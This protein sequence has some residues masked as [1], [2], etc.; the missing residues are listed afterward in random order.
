MAVDTQ[1]GFG[2][3]IRRRRVAAGLTQEELAE[4]TGLSVRAIRDIERGITPK[5]HRSSVDLLMAALGL[6]QE[7]QS[8][9][10]PFSSL[11][12][13]QLP[14]AV[15][16]FVGRS[17]ELA[18]L[19][20]LLGQ[21]DGAPGTTLIS[22]ICGAPGVG[23]TTLAVHWAHSV[24]SQ[25]PDG[26]LYLNLRG[27]DSSGSVMS[28]PEAIGRILDAMQIPAEQRPESPDAR[29]DLYR[30]LLA[31]KRM[32]VVLDNARD[33]DQVRLLLPGSP[34][35]AV[36]IT[37]RSQLVGMVATQDAHPMKLEPLDNTEARELLARR[38]GP[39]R[40]RTESAAVDRLI[41]LSAGLPLALAIVAA[42]AALGPPGLLMSLLEQLQDGQGSLAA[43][44]A[45]DL[46]LD[47]QTVFSWSYQSLSAPAARMFRLLGLHPGPDINMPAAASLAGLSQ[48]E[49]RRVL[50]ELARTNLV[51]EHPG[52]RY[53]FHDL[54]RAYSRQLAAETDTEDERRQ[55][56]HRVLDYY[57]GS[58]HAAAELVHPAHRHAPVPPLQPGVLEQH[59]AD[60]EQA[61]A[62]FDA[63]RHVLVAAVVAAAAAGFDN[64]VV[65]TVGYLSKYLER[66]GY[67]VD[68]AATQQIAL[69]AAERLGDQHAEARAHLRLGE[70]A[71]ELG[72]FDEATEHFEQALELERESG[73]LRGQGRALC[74]RAFSLIT[75]GKFADAIAGCQQALDV[76]ESVDDKCGQAAV[77]NNISWCHA[78]LDHDPAAVDYAKRSLALYQE[79]DDRSGESVAWDTLGWAYHRRGDFPAAI[80]CYQKAAAMAAE[81]GARVRQATTLDQ[82]GDAYAQT[83]DDQSAREAWRTSAEIL[84]DMHHADASQVLDKLQG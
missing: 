78:S 51:D 58:A 55:A 56:L 5:P 80:S 1:E 74:S 2:Q 72:H 82:L 45:G 35:C 63:E 68:T 37:S 62:W 43:L 23:K 48:D 31:G 30:S 53:T 24:A 44:D 66:R 71:S 3:L 28:A 7:S 4:R 33:D 32:L 12:P 50:Q 27:F 79:L 14:A 59:F 77:L 38:L 60:P 42:Q 10:H 40:V 46:S 34:G 36:L 11:I 52:S 6:A 9:A 67:L 17:A 18:A 57:Q 22:V 73:D 47:P 65:R 20:E 61:L 54:L 39:D 19:D 70:G 26:Q 25:F 81:V 83:G 84:E 15:R 64:H 29:A 41:G 69:A 76:F 8:V 75:Q 16:H 21:L 13:R 49:A